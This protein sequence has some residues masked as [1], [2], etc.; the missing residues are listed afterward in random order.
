M[1]PGMKK[2]L[3]L[4]GC[5]ALAGCANF[6][7]DGAMA[8]AAAGWSGASASYAPVAYTPQPRQPVSCFA[9]ANGR[10]AWCY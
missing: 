2:A 8:G 6:D 3:V 5:L 9:S 1:L 4:I 10:Q 7:W